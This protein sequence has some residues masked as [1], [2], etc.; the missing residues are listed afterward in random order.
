MALITV[1]VSGTHW[2]VLARY[3]LS[4]VLCCLAS[5]CLIL[6]LLRFKLLFE[7]ILQ[8]IGRFVLLKFELI[9]NV[10]CIARGLFL[11]ESLIFLLESILVVL[12]N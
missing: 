5:H 8:I 7:S 12:V 6:T 10:N 9:S 2:H 3:L 1:G 11:N 4:L